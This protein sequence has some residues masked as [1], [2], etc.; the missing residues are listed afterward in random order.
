MAA[1]KRFMRLFPP[2]PKARAIAGQPPNLGWGTGTPAGTIA[3]FSSQPIGTIY[4]QADALATVGALWQKLDNNAADAD[5]ELVGQATLPPI[6]VTSAATTLSRIARGRTVTLSR[7][8]GIAVTLP[9]A[10]GSGDKYKLVII[11]TFTGAATIKVTGDDIMKGTAILFA[12]GGDTVVGF[13]TAVDSDTVD[14]LGTGNSTGG[15]S[16][17]QYEFEDIA[18]DTWSVKIASD[19]AGTEA[20]PFSATV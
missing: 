16:G 9:P 6:A 10:T 12:D 3:D 18:A 5:W 20:T 4:L 7:A 13:A 15:I 14:M 11:T 17:A 8:A 2:L 19:A 1:S